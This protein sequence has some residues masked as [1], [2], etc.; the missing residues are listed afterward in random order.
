VLPFDEAGGLVA[1]FPGL[2]AARLV[3]DVDDGQP[4]Q[5]DHSVVTRLVAAGLG[6]LA[7]LVIQRLDLF[8]PSHGCAER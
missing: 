1:A 5:L 8:N 6:D 7:E 4:Q 2:L 3:L